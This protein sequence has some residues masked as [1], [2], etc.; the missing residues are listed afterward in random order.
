MFKG[1]ANIDPSRRGPVYRFKADITQLRFGDLT[2]MIIPLAS[3][4][5]FAVGF[6]HLTVNKPGLYTL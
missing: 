5:I 6:D 4:K 3:K 2:D 1:K